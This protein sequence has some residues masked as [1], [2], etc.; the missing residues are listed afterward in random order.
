MWSA[1][2]L[3]VISPNKCCDLLYTDNR[4]AILMTYTVYW[5]WPQIKRPTQ[6]PSYGVWREIFH[7]QDGLAHKRSD[8]FGGPKS[9][10]MLSLHQSQV[11]DITKEHSILAKKGPDN[12]YCQGRARVNL[13]NFKWVLI[14]KKRPPPSNYSQ[15]THL[16]H[17]LML[18][19]PLWAKHILYP[20]LTAG[21]KK[22]KPPPPPTASLQQ[23]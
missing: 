13:S 16:I 12:N 11:Y 10:D 9:L 18:I 2:C 23:L 4:A 17:V 19:V 6:V 7:L 22:F 14:K 3:L 15:L 20:P 1:S 21:G 5:P 8:R